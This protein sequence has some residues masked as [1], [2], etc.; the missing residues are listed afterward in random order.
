VSTIYFSGLGSGIDTDALVKELMQLERQSINRVQLQKQQ[1]QVKADAWRD[2]RVR[3]VNLQQTAQ[4]LLQ[5]SLYNQKAAISGNESLVSAVAG[6]DAANGSYQLEILALARAHSVASLTAAAITGDVEAGSKSALNLTGTLLINEVE[7]T[8][9]ESDSLQDICA[10]I[11]AREEAGVTA[12]IIDRR[13]MLTR[14]ETGAVEIEIG[15]NDL[16]RALGLQTVQEGQDAEL[17]LNGLEV[18]RPGNLI[19]DLL[20]GVTLKLNQ[21][22][23]GPVTITVKDDHS[24]LIGKI[25]SFIQQY[26]STCQFIR[27]QTAVDPAAGLK[28]PLQGES[29]LYQVLATIER[30]VNGAAEGAG[31]YRC[32]AAIGIG[33][34]G[35]DSA[36]PLGTLLLDQGKLEEALAA[37]PAA[38]A[39]LFAGEQ[40]VAARLESYIGG[41]TRYGEGLFH[42]HSESIENQI[43]NL[44]RRAEALELRLEKREQTLR[45]QFLTVERLLGQ[46][47]SQSQWLTQQLALLTA[48]STAISR[49][50]R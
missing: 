24:L 49:Q 28:G 3:L 35:W 18:T 39:A 10:R 29:S 38:V 36:E 21:A 13:L 25:K 30:T 20:D 6:T 17:R 48:Q 42:Y 12:A 32:L 26:N 19:D 2:L 50:N 44:D 5:S 4:G 22:G 46:M 27:S 7:I 33:T 14:T 15:D 41:L 11:N 8:V 45:Q 31:S 16:G 37:D 40:G 9:A 43:K 47:S 23:G 34:A 1:L